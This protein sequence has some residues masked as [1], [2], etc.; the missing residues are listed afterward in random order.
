MKISHEN[1]LKAILNFEIMEQKTSVNNLAKNLSVKPASVTE[2]IKKLSA[3]EYVSHENYRGFKLTSKGKAIATRVLRRHRLWET[4]LF[5]V[6]NFNWAEVH[7][8]ADKF[9]HITSDTMEKRMDDLLGNP[10]FDPHGHPIPFPDGTWDN[11]SRRAGLSSLSHL[12]VGDKA[13]IVQVSDDNP[14]LLE[15]MAKRDL[16]LNSKIEVIDKIKFDDSMEIKS[17]TTMVYFSRL[18]AEKIDVKKTGEEK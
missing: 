18:M 5:Q 12:K 13:L 14:S 1:Y 8:E 3:M 6:L 7:E 4:F 17:G 10:E 2:M 11:S 15:Y 16:Y 9:E